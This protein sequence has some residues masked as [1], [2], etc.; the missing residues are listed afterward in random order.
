M[1]SPNA[2][3]LAERWQPIARFRLKVDCL[4]LLEPGLRDR[5]RPGIEVSLTSDVTGR[6]LTI[7]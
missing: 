4:S 1:T 5:S 3:R 6:S 2:I 7:H